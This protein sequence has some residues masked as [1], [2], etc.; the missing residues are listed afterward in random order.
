[1]KTVVLSGATAC[2]GLESAMQIGAQGAHL[3]LVG[4]NAAKLQRAVDDVTAAGAGAVDSHLC[5]FTSLDDVRALA[6]AVLA[7]T[8]ISTYSSTMSAPSTPNER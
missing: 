5:D 6:G 7:A 1:M 4:R 8:T 2:I 3:V